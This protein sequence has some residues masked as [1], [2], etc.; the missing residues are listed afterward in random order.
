MPTRLQRGIKCAR[1]V[2][3]CWREAT[4]QKRVTSTAT[5]TSWE[6]RATPRWTDTDELSTPPQL[7]CVTDMAQSL[8]MRSSVRQ[9]GVALIISMILLLVITLIGVAVMGGLWFVL[10]LFFFC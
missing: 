1:S 2:F 8:T 5:L 10:L 4:V 7:R 6:S 3:G 9:Q